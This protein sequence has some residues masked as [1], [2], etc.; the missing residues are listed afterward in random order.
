MR[1]GWQRYEM[2]R[3]VMKWNFALRLKLTVLSLSCRKSEPNSLASSSPVLIRLFTYYFM[4]S[5][6]ILCSRIC[7][8]SIY[9]LKKKKNVYF[10]F[11]GG[12]GGEGR[13]RGLWCSAFDVFQS[14]R[15]EVEREFIYCQSHLEMSMSLFSEIS[16]F[17]TKPPGPTTWV[18]KTVPTTRTGFR[19]MTHIVRTRKDPHK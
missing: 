14:A 18:W 16:I 8:D 4:N 7:L 10:P 5:D 1:C 17:Q 2:K 11:W 6:R 19:I 13:G 3:N 15:K 9:A 12:D